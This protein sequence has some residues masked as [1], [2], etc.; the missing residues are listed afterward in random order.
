MELAAKGVKPVTLELGG[1]SPL[2]IFS[3]CVLDNAVKGALMANFLTQ[4]EVCSSWERML[5][6]CLCHI[7]EVHFGTSSSVLLGLEKKTAMQ[8]SLG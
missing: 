3:D 4:G 8:S 5:E 6:S 1:K 7:R 2:I